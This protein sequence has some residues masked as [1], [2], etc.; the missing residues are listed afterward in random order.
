VSK[1]ISRYADSRIGGGTHDLSG[2]G[3]TA[4][5][6]V[7]RRYDG[8][9]A[10]AA[11]RLAGMLGA[12]ALALLAWAI[13][14]SPASATFLHTDNPSIVFGPDGTDDITP[15]NSFYSGT[16]R[17]LAVDSQRQRLYVLHNVDPEVG[18]GAGRGIYG[19]DISDPQNPEPL[20]G[21]F[22][23]PISEQRQGYVQIAIDE[24][25]GSIYLLE[26][27]EECFCEPGGDLYSWDAEGKPR[28]GYPTHIDKFG[29]LA[30]DPSGYLW[31][32]REYA[33]YNI[34]A[35]DFDLKKY[36]PDGTYVETLTPGLPDAV[37]GST[38]FHFNR[39][40]G[41]LYLQYTRHL[42][43]FTADSD[44]TY[45]EPPI[46]I[47]ERY[48]ESIDVDNANGVIYSSFGGAGASIEA[49]NEQGGLAEDPFGVGGLR[50]LNY[51]K[52]GGYCPADVPESN[53]RA[54]AVDETSGT[55][56]VVNDSR[57]EDSN[58]PEKAFKGG[59][60]EAF[61]GTG[62][63]D[64]RTG[65]PSVVGKADATLTG[66][67]GP[68]EGPP[69][70][71]C[72]FKYVDDVSYGNVRVVSIDGATGG[73]FK[74]GDAQKWTSSNA[75]AFDVEHSFEYA[76]P[77]V[78]GPPGGPWRIETVEA[79]ERGQIERKVRVAGNELKP[80]GTRVR[81]DWDPSAAPC[82]PATSAGSPLEAPTD[83]KADISGLSA[84]TT[85]HYRVDA[86]SA[87]GTVRGGVE[88]FTTTS[89]EVSTGPATEVA[90]ESATL[91]GTV[92]PENLATTY[93]FEY[94]RT[95]AYGSTTSTPPGDD[96]GTTTPGDQPVSEPISG[97]EPGKIYH[98]RIVAVN[99][100][101]TS[102][103]ADRTFTTVG[104]VRDLE[105]LPAT[106]VQRTQAMLHG[107]LDPDGI[108]THYYF[109]WGTS[110]RYGQSSAAPPGT[111]LSDTSPGDQ[112]LSF[113]AT[114]LKAGTT[115]HYRL[116]GVSSFGTT[117]GNDQT[118]S[119][120]TAVKA[121]ATDPAT[122]IG[123]AQATLNGTL[124]PDG[125]PTTFY[126][127]Y[128]KTTAYGQTAPVAPGE[129][130]G[131]DSPGVRQVS[132]VL[133]SLEPGTTYHYRLV[134]V[135]ETGVSIAG[136]QSFK[137]KHGPTI[138]GVTTSGV[139]ATGAELK[140]RINPHGFQT[141][142][143]FEYGLTT[144]YGQTA[145]V[146]NGILGPETS[147][148]PVTVTLTGL[149]E[150]TYHFRLIAKSA[151]GTMVSEDQTFE[152]APPACPNSAVRQQTGS[153]YLPD[154]RA[155]ELVTPARAGGATIWAAAPA[156]QMDGD[157]LAY[158]AIFNVIPGTDAPNGGVGSPEADL[159]VATRT[160]NGW[161][162][163]YVGVKGNEALMSHQEL[164]GPRYEGLS[165][166]PADE[167]LERFLAWEHRFPCCGDHGSYAPYLY[168]AQ[169][170]FLGRLPTNAH[171]VPGAL[172][173]SAYT[174]GGFRGDSAISGDGRHYVFSSTRM[175]FT[176]DGLTP[177][178]GSAYVNNIATG[179]VQKISV[180]E[181]GEDL[182]Q[183]PLVSGAGEEF[184]KFPWVSR[185]AG[186][187]L[188]SL[189]GPSEGQNGPGTVHLYMHV[190]GKGT[191]DVS[192]DHTGV[193]RGV[194]YDG[195]ARDGSE[196]F[197]TTPHQMTED[198]DDQSADL[199]RWSETTND[200][201]RLSTG[202]G[203]SGNTDF[204]SGSW[205]NKCGVE[206]VP[207]GHRCIAPDHPEQRSCSDTPIA[208]DT[209]EI[210]FYSPEQLDEGAKGVAGARNLYVWRNGQPR[211]V[212]KLLGGQPIERINVS[213]DGNWMAF[214]T[215]SPIT[216]YDNAD[217]SEMY[218]FNAVDRSI[219]CVS[220]R[221]DG[222]P[223]TSNVLGSFNGYFMTTDG[224]TFFS[225]QEALV[226]RDADGVSD[227]YEYTGGRPH[228]IS[229]GAE[230]GNGNV[231]SPIGLIGVTA[232][233]QDAFFSTYQTLVGQDENG[234]LYKIYD[235]R[236]NGGFPFQRPPAPCAAAD[237]CHGEGAPVPARPVIGSTANL[238]QRGNF[239]AKR[240]K[241]Q[242]KQRKKQRRRRARNRKNKSGKKK[243]GG[244]TGQKKKHGG[245]RGQR[246]AGR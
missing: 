86:T 98:Y 8:S 76:I 207:M 234:P 244:R 68:G 47:A 89:S 220:C 26:R 81:V 211:F 159:Y 185:D 88:S 174:E 38:D 137:T 133:K 80:D 240:K 164:W 90:R 148:Q 42:V 20:G 147:G 170:T 60:I 72:E 69:V 6:A 77:N 39:I 23:L 110:K 135:N 104:A 242:K 197:F 127:E 151:W 226:N 14:A 236:V 55:V 221:P 235:A 116:V 223:P 49:I 203:G 126:F 246:G 146:P 218:R 17:D 189:G 213:F 181:A 198:D 113:L 56:Y 28:P 41:D 10:P 44:Y 215:K 29:P 91:N 100:N 160:L 40:T 222:K 199:F 123:T 165:G 27:A 150:S 128:G 67:V 107:K 109:E 93:Y 53:N 124:D 149:Q 154:C 71:R 33:N 205:T 201:T 13:G 130:V 64:S 35:S 16:I 169:G 30:V 83:V 11:L 7:R 54:L 15:E 84:G 175:A 114:G 195:A 132:F 177:P 163:D 241:H 140:A 243:Q 34:P 82:E 2:T 232:D 105:T 152:F 45:H 134:A 217:L 225:T 122:D 196:V 61:I 212:A 239:T 111:D 50:E 12:L 238:G 51:E 4:A 43:K 228:L 74:L 22:P 75:T 24:D 158:G 233:G 166:I 85:Y 216:A 188:M 99:A 87:A 97:L 156:S 48:L 180:D 210:Y 103:G 129:A 78:T 157:H 121:L 161:Q 106:D 52:C 167:N 95:P 144:A 206:V 183:D 65:S 138:E 73:R 173:K 108:E 58:A 32:W 168:D 18:P 119:T 178:P 209:G 31:V 37:G 3:A 62:G 1:A 245:H 5:P 9:G 172:E 153:N 231:L 19:Y 194:R 70:T 224:R 184:I 112:Q 202:V 208:R 176:P 204:C 141:E 190:R 139:N 142:W 79:G 155:Y 25:D 131:D 171:E 200:L 237:E 229:N 94:G 96:L 230:T 219:V 57:A 115:Y 92:D 136:N 162:T 227:T 182:E 36:L 125:M 214:L 192:T 117:Y 66:R 118:F 186:H 187:V 191:F 101:G 143:Y 145:P 102:K 59:L 193:D 120:P 46:P 63:P 21:N 179:Q